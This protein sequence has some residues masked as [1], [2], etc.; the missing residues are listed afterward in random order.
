[1]AMRSA[2]T[3]HIEVQKG[4][5]CLRSAFFN[6]PFKIANITEDKRGPFLDLM[7]MC[8]SPGVLDGDE[9][10]IRVSLGPDSRLRLHTQ[11]Y[12]RLFQMKNGATQSMEVRLERGACFCWLP[13]PSVPHANSVFTSR[14][15]IFLAEDARLIWGEILT[16][17]RKLSGEVFAL[18]SYHSRTEVFVQDQ[19][20]LLENLYLRP[21]MLPVA[22]LGQLEGY[23]HQASLLLVGFPADPSLRAAIG[24]CCQSM[25]H[26]ISTGPAN[27]L[28]IRLLGN[29]AEPLYE[30]F[31]AIESLLTP[32]IPILSPQPATHAS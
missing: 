28:I 16:C 15:R 13:H 31:Q 5:S 2:V 4:I 3:I 10:T 30:C 21:S 24:D 6:P 23:T 1:M 8:S 12:Q 25:V 26:G 18:S 17:G 27:S 7:L 9:Q 29:K 20:A 14:N 11:S 19:L 22:A 32:T